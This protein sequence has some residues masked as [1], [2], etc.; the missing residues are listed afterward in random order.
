MTTSVPLETRRRRR[1]S[2]WIALAGVLVI[3]SAAWIATARGGASHTV[4]RWQHLPDPALQVAVPGAT[5]A[6]SG[7]AGAGT[8][9]LTQPLVSG[10]VELLVSCSGAGTISFVLGTAVGGGDC[11]RGSDR[12]F[13]VNIKAG[14]PRSSALRVEAPAGL[15]WRVSLTAG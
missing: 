1:R 8:V 4:A 11:A 2:W 7:G 13:V 15:L 3:G 6:A 14:G 10:S 9:A 5:I 12:Q